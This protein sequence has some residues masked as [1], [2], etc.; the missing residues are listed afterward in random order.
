[1]HL[2]EALKLI[3]DRAEEIDDVPL[4]Y[5]LRRYKF[6]PIRQGTVRHLKLCLAIDSLGLTITASLINAFQH[7]THS[8]E[9]LHNLG[10]KNILVRKRKLGLSEW[11]VHPAFKRLLTPKNKKEVDECSEVD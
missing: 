9:T 8:W 3:L 6:K 10:D 1:M 5:A 7:T 11:I 2:D 4:Y